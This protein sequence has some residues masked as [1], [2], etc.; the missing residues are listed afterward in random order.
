MNN[1]SDLAINRGGNANA[2]KSGGR[3]I[4]LYGK[5]EDEDEEEEPWQRS[6]RG[7]EGPSRPEGCC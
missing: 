3:G 5:E 4:L 2:V 6:G 1:S 7:G